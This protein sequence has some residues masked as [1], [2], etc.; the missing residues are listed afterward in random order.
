[1]TDLRVAVVGVG[2]IGQAHLFAV[3]S[4][5]GMTLAGVCDADAERAARAASD[6]DTIVFNT[7]TTLCSSGEVDAVVI[8]T[9]PATHAPLVREAIEAGVHVYCE[10]PFTLIARDGY[11]LGQLAAER[12]VVVQVGLQFRYHRA[13]AAMRHMVTGGDTGELFRANLLATNWFRAQEYFAA[14]PWRSAWRSSGGGVLI[15]QAIHQL[16]ALITTVGMPSRVHAGWYCAAHVAEVEDELH[17]MLEWP[18]GARG[19]LSASMNDPAGREEFALHGDRGAVIVQDY[20]FRRAEYESVQRTIK[21]SEEEFP[22]VTAVWEQVPIE[23]KSSEWFD[24]IIDC[25][26]DFARAIT[27]GI[28]NA[29]PPMEGTRVVEL[30]NACYLSAAHDQPVAL[31]LAGDE[32]ATTFDRLG[33]GSLAVPGLPIA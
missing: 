17:A 3:T 23:R 27:D 29:I 15:T 25:H 21:E 8:A 4:I 13:Y 14:S 11:E 7:F 10:K 6:H 24:M 31:P 22:S 32:Y 26:R 20:D 2:G 9:P 30:V 28:P 19:T 18:N 12:G 33:D 5:D 1:M 16:D